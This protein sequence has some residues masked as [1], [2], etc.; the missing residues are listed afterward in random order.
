MSSFDVLVSVC[1][2]QLVSIIHFYYVCLLLMINFNLGIIW[3]TFSFSFTF[4]S[5]FIFIDCVKLNFNAMLCSLACFEL[6]SC[7]ILIFELRKIKIM[8]IQMK[9]ILFFWVIHLIFR[10]KYQKISYLSDL[11][12][13]ILLFPTFSYDCFYY[14]YCC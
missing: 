10:T 6:F 7:S 4:V 11:Y 5:I 13:T 3:R 12:S 14:C 9:M 1:F 8:L 2:C